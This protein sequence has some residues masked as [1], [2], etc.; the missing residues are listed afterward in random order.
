[1]LR[2]VSKILSL[3]LLICGFANASDLISS[4][5]AGAEVY[6]ISPE[7]EQVV[8]ESF[9]VSF[10]LKGMGVA[11]AGVDAKN[12]GHHHILINTDIATVDLTQPLPANDNIRHFGGGQ[13]ETTLTLPK[14]KHTLRLLLGNYVRIPH[15]KPVMS[16]E[17]TVI[18]E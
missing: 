17:I 7:N 14:G 4:A 13:T 15:E 1:M 10:G 12:T 8:E 5:P 9:R 11:P 3:S 16:E 18:V 6:F 2:V